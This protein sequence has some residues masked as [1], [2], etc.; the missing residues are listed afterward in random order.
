MRIILRKRYKKFLK[1]CPKPDVLVI[2]DEKK[3]H[4]NFKNSKKIL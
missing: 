2:F 3:N 4:C 1:L